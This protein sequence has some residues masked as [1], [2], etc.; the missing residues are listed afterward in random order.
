MSLKLL[1]EF[2]LVVQNSRLEASFC[3]GSFSKDL[4]FLF[5][6]TW[7]STNEEPLGD[8]MVL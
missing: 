6:T 4:F 1:N 8:S 5:E 7:P 3:N 2:K